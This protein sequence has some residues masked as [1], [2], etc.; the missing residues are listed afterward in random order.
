MIESG[1]G[2]VVS[3]QI[4]DNNDGIIMFD[5]S[6]NVTDNSIHEN[7]RTGMIISGCSFPKVQFNKIYGNSTS[8]IILRDDSTGLITNNKVRYPTKVN[9]DL[10]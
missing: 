9:F 6:P 7:Q 2:W 1:Y 4:Y 3:N 8:G 10:L 5:S